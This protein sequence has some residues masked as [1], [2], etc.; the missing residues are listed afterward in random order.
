M[1]KPLGPMTPHVK[2]SC[3]YVAPKDKNGQ[4]YKM[5]LACV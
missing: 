2:R 4:N 1:E 5:T 3:M